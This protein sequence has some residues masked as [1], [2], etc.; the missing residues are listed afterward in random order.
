VAALAG[1]GALEEAAEDLR[2][3]EHKLRAVEDRLEQA[4]TKTIWQGR[5]A[6]ELRSRAGARRR[7]LDGAADALRGAHR[8]LDRA[9]DEVRTA[10]RRVEAAE[11]TWAV[12]Q[13]Q[14]VAPVPASPQPP[15]GDAGWPAWLR[16]VTGQAAGAA[17]PTAGRSA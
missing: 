15:P 8:S 13:A 11:Q 7:E 16:G 5:G 2:R 4:T 3:W 14:G 9:A 17:V 10:R 1:V 6:E 12:L